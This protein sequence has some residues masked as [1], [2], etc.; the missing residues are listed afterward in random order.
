MTKTQAETAAK[1][2]LNSLPNK[3]GWKTRIWENLGWCWSLENGPISVYPSTLP[4]HFHCMIAPSIEER[5]CGA[6]E[7]TDCSKKR[8]TTPW[9]AVLQEVEIVRKHIEEQTKR[10]AALSSEFDKVMDG[11]HLIV[12]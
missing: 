12:P 10:Y 3:K 6:G 5:G 8:C 7:W 11:S 1:L 9:D 2:A 4:G